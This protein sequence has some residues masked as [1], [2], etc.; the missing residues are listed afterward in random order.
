[1]Y[2]LIYI[3]RKKSYTYYSSHRAWCYEP[4]YQLYM[5]VAQR[6][7][8][9]EHFY[10]EEKILGRY[11]VVSLPPYIKEDNTLINGWNT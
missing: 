6:E 3:A 8:Q 4:L 5:D 10:R 2:I 7:P 1:M 9:R 11:N